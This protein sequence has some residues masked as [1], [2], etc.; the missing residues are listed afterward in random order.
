MRSQLSQD[1]HELLARVSYRWYADGR[2]QEQIAREF[3]LSR[4]K[5]QRLLEQARAAGVVDIH[6]DV[7]VGLDLD[8]EARLV[9]TFGLTDAIV[10]AAQPTVEATRESLGRA[11][12][13]YLA[14]HLTEGT[15]V[16][17]GHGRDV[18]AIPPGFR[19]R[20]DG[21]VF[22]SA[23]GGS[24]RVDTPTNPNEIVASLA[25]AS[26][27]RAESLYAPAYVESPEIRDQLRAQEAVAHAVELAVGAS[28]A[29]VGIGGTDD[30]C[31]MV[32]S[33]CLSQREIASLRGRGA[34][35]DILGNYVDAD[36]RLITAPH[37]ERL[38]ALGLDELRRIP[39]VVAVASGPEKPLAIF[40]VL[41]AGIVDVL[42]V[43][44]V[45]ARTVLDYAKAGTDSA[46]GV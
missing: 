26:G 13:R 32:R 41:R 28:M 37:S 46:G 24:P 18:G 29:L 17:V 30:E 20:A 3:G 23:M 25:A 22:V 5:V 16:A 6:I 19:A 1:E 39:T 14:R 10:S 11:A 36:G 35:G 33:G 12:A 27:G 9:D 31:T 2:T 7:P 34:V 8:L 42:I 45:N 4:P 38:M 43:D 44:E 15:T 21:C 40:G